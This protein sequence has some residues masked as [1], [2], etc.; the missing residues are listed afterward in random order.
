MGTEGFTYVDKKT[1][2]ARI[3][4]FHF[5]NKNDLTIFCRVIIVSPSGDIPDD[6]NV[7]NSLIMNNI[8]ET[9]IYNHHS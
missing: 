4:A 7:R 1:V 9:N 3:N 8:S 2:V 5:Q 6:K